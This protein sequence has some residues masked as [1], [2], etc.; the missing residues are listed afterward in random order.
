MAKQLGNGTYLRSR[1]GSFHKTFLILLGKCST[2]N[3]NKV[4]I[5]KNDEK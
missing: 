4:I 5:S 3:K 2:F 1:Q